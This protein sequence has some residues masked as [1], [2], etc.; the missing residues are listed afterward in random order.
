MQTLVITTEDDSCKWQQLECDVVNILTIDDV[1]KKS[2][3]SIQKS[4]AIEFGLSICNP[5]TYNL[6]LS[7]DRLLNLYSVTK[8][9]TE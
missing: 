3:E 8:V 7:E 5:I 6:P 1:T 4:E 9:K 2:S